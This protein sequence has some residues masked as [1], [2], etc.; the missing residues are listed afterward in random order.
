MDLRSD[1]FAFLLRVMRARKLVLMT[2]TAAEPRLH[3]DREAV[4][5]LRRLRHRMSW[6]LS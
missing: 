6:F 2:R 3:S 4:V 1:V 5:Q